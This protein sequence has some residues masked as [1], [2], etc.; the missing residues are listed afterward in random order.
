VGDASVVD[1]D[2]EA[3]EF[4]AGGVEEGVDGMRVADVGG[5]SQDFHFLARQFPAEF[6]ECEWVAGGED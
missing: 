2:V 5:V 4:A 6:S 3:F 1:K